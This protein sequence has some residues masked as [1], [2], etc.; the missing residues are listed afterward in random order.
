MHKKHRLWKRRISTKDKAVLKEYKKVRN[1]AKRE[2]VKLTQQ[3]Q[4][5]ISMDCKKNL[6]VWQYVNK[7]TASRSNVGDLKWLDSDGNKNLAEIDT[8]CQSVWR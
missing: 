6:K 1:H 7:H 3:E 4:H 8:E 5:R 2:T